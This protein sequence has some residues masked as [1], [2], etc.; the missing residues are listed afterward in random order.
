MVWKC[1]LCN[2]ELTSQEYQ[3]ETEDVSDGWTWEAKHKDEYCNKKL[4]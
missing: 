3:K 2:E 1:P 4:N